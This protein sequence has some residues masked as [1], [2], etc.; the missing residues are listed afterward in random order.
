MKPADTKKY[1]HYSP[2]HQKSC[3]KRDVSSLFNRVYSITTN[4][5]D[6]T[7]ENARI[8]QALLVKFLREFPTRIA[9]LSHNSKCKSQISDKKILFFPVSVF[10]TNIHEWTT[11]GGGNYLLV[12]SP[13]L[14]PA[15][16]T[17]RHQPRHYSRELTSAHSQQL[18]LKRKL[19]VSKFK[20]LT[21][22]LRA[23]IRK[24]RARSE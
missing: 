6:L 22:K 10:F 20:L 9:R 12:S 17:L 3:N 11:E 14:S 23:L 15:S 2:H 19:S 16:Q 18:D 8:K 4:Q 24:I 21:T 1:L 7:K 13:P 5:D